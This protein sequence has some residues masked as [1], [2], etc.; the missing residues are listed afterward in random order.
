[1]NTNV[2]D[3][4]LDIFSDYVSDT[5]GEDWCWEYFG[6]I[7]NNYG[8]RLSMDYALGHGKIYLYSHHGIED[9]FQENTYGFG[10]T[11]CVQNCV[12]DE[13]FGNGYL[14]LFGNGWTDSTGNGF[15]ATFDFFDFS[16]KGNG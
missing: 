4:P 15:N 10:R 1:M 16:Y 9:L 13:P 12:D 2:G 5:L 3:M 14:L 8:H 7:V 11:S 6:L